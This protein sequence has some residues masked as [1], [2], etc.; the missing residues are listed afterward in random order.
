MY[1]LFPILLKSKNTHTRKI[2]KC[3][4]LQLKTD[5][6]FILLRDD[7]TDDPNNID[8]CKREQ[9]ENRIK[10]NKIEFPYRIFYFCKVVNKYMAQIN[11]M[12]WIYYTLT[13]NKQQHHQQRRTSNEQHS[14]NTK[15]TFNPFEFKKIWEIFF[16]HFHLLLLNS[17]KKK[18]FP[19]VHA[20]LTYIHK[21]CQ[22]FVHLS[23]SP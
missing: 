2:T 4:I 14:T 11:R 3:A 21:A 19:F 6:Q 16:N 22:Y 7:S 9:N 13:I 5:A 17:L 12:N 15:V 10:S 18:S 23:C 20:F 1:Q 8:T